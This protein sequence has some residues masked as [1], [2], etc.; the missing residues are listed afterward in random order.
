MQQTDMQ[1]QQE[2]SVYVWQQAVRE[3]PILLP[4]SLL[5]IWIPYRW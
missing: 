1:E 5:P 2:K 3:Q 4:E